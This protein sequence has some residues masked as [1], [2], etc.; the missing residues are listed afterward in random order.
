[1]QMYEK[2]GLV[3]KAREMFQLLSMLV[4]LMVCN[5]CFTYTAESICLR[6]HD[7]IQIIERRGDLSNDQKSLSIHLKKRR[8]YC[9][10][11]FGIWKGSIVEEETHV[12]SL[13]RPESLADI[14]QFSFTVQM[15]RLR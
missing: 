9:R 12:Y 14:Q 13:T 3:A 11:P 7:D 8:D 2:K 15:A 5:G 4:L 6:C 10:D 1:M